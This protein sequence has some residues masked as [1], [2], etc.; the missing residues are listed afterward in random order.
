MS[1][2]YIREQYQVPAKRGMRTRFKWPLEGILSRGGKLHDGTIVAARGEH[3]RVRFDGVPGIFTIHPTW[4]V[5]YLKPAPATGA[6]ALTTYPLT[7]VVVCDQCGTETGHDYVVHDLM[8]REQRL[9]TAR[10][11]LARNEGWSCD[12]AGDFCP[13]CRQ[14]PA[15]ATGVCNQFCDV[16]ADG[17]RYCGDLC[18]LAGK[19]KRHRCPRHEVEHGLRVTAG[20]TPAPTTEEQP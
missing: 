11:H 1:M 4:E 3:I 12:S 19:H 13:A 6:S 15:P 2:A 9:G 14:T 8:T 16:T 18:A 10:S 5:E 7:I 17:E 20:D